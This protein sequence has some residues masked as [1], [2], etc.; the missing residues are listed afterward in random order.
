M[1]SVVNVIY[2]KIHQELIFISYH[3]QKKGK[4]YWDES[5]KISK[6]KNNFLY[7]SQFLQPIMILIIFFCN[8]KIFILSGEFPQNNKT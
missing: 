6:L 1:L 4:M 5:G 7:E 2:L 8:L 3:K